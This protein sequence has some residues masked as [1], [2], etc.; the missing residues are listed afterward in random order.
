M[1]QLAQLLK[2]LVVGCVLVNSGAALAQTKDP[3]DESNK[4]QPPEKAQ[5]KDPFDESNKARASR[6]GSGAKSFQGSST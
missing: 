5:T 1:S 4:A 6:K 3:F 2:L